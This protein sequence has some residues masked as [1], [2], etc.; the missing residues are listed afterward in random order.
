MAADIEMV[1]GADHDSNG[2][3]GIEDL[4]TLKEYIRSAV[5]PI[6]RLAAQQP[7][8]DKDTMLQSHAIAALN[9]LAWS[10]SCIDF[11]NGENVGILKAWKPVARKIWDSVVAPVLATDTADV[12]LAT[13]T[14]GLAWALARTIRGSIS[15]E[16]NPH[17]KF[18]A[19]YQATKSMDGA[20]TG[21]A[22]DDPE[23]QDPMQSLGVKCIG[24]LGQLAQVPMSIPINREIGVF[25]VR[26]LS[27]LP[28]TPVA[29]AIE[30]VDQIF[31]LYSD[32]E[33]PWDREVFW[34]DN[35]LQH[36]EEAAPK[37]KAAAKKID[38]RTMFELRSRADEASLNLTR[39]LQYKRKH[40][41]GH[42]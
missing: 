26:V 11:S 16:G 39:L 4:P 5:P 12:N 3:P 8:S 30:A 25:L 34:K 2:V 7:K 19:L 35:F 37:L 14:T 1:T 20:T 17:K 15:T 21:T 29:E 40:R 28:E 36:L 33:A 10:V 42:E 22:G 31:D 41:P 32:E 24:V 6:T 9:N 18:M 27:A 38:K 23:E 13:K